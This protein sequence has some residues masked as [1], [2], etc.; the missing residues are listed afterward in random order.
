M[1]EILDDV[2]VGSVGGLEVLDGVRVGSIGRL[3][4]MRVGCVEWCEC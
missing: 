1:L 2:T 3:E 4:R